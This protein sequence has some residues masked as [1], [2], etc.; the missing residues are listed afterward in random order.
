M[1]TL[2][3]IAIVQFFCYAVFAFDSVREY[4]DACVN[5]VPTCRCIDDSIE[6]IYTFTTSDNPQEF[7]VFLV[8]IECLDKQNDGNSPTDSYP[9]LPNKNVKCLEKQPIWAHVRLNIDGYFEKIPSNAFAFPKNIE[10][11]DL[12]IGMKQRKFLR[13]IDDDAFLGADLSELDYLYLTISR[14]FSNETGLNAIKK[15][16]TAKRC[17][18]NAHLAALSASPWAIGSFMRIFI[19]QKCFK[20]SLNFLSQTEVTIDENVSDLLGLGTQVRIAAPMVI[21]SQNAFI[22]SKLYEIKIENITSIGACILKRSSFMRL[23]LQFKPNWPRIEVSDDAFACMSYLNREQ[24]NFICSMDSAHSYSFSS[25][26]MICNHA[27]SKRPWR[28]NIHGDKCLPL[29]G[30]S[31]C[32]TKVSQ[33]NEENEQ[34]YTFEITATEVEGT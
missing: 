27:A 4:C 25:S 33:E 7:T 8:S 20:K 22:N 10:I 6:A 18:E 1:Q 5:T 17:L 34:I 15:L 23:N 29:L 24:I 21:L 9:Y 26:S 3:H 30:S 32:L 14:D 31:K 28:I 11:I 2:R 19:S 16:I 13:Q 12:R